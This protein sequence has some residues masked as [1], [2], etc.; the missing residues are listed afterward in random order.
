MICAHNNL[1]HSPLLIKKLKVKLIQCTFLL[2]KIRYLSVSCQIR[3]IRG[4]SANNAIYRA[5][6]PG[7]CKPTGIFC[8]K[9]MSL[10][11]RYLSVLST[12]RP[13]KNLR[14]GVQIQRYKFL[15][16]L[17]QFTINELKIYRSL[18]VLHSLQ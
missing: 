6:R 4:A 11:V 14:Y 1:S 10:F 18:N 7:I 2:N 15:A 16:P 8:R 5:D 3:Y 9:I 13:K 12:P 17:K